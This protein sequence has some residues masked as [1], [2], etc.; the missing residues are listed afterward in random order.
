ME[1]MRNP[2]P[3]VSRNVS[4]A[5]QQILLDAQDAG[6]NLD[7]I[8][9]NPKIKGRLLDDQAALDELVDLSSRGAAIPG[10][11]LT[12]DPEQPYPWEKPAEFANPREA[13]NDILTS[14]LQPEAVKEIINSLSKGASVGDLATAIAYAKF[15]EGKINPDVMLLVMEPIMY[16]IM[17][18]A[19]EA[20]IQYNI[21][22]DD[23]DEPDE[24]E[25]AQKLKE[26]E[27]AFQQIKAGTR[28]K[29]ISPEKLES[30]VVDKGLLDR[31]KQAGP[32]I[33]E[34]LLEKGEE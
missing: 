30:G 9:D 16:L 25:V 19:E 17:G 21:D 10:Q 12:N 7:D 26:V 27:D 18:I 29:E 4:D 34:S 1:E 14:L 3:V 2:R 15:A 13:L 5:V 31:V 20:N 11:S 22:G 28:E 23:L 24:E 8:E 6:V 32:N 33:R